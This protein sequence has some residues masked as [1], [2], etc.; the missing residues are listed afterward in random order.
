MAVVSVESALETQPLAVGSK[1]EFLA[2]TNSAEVDE[3]MGCELEE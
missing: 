3:A 2:L 1:T